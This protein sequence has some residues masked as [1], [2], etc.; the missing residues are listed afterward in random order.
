MEESFQSCF[1]REIRESVGYFQDF[2]FE[3]NDGTTFVLEINKK[4]ISFYGID[5]KRIFDC[6][7]L[8]KNELLRMFSVQ[9]IFYYGPNV[10]CTD[11]WNITKY[12]YI[13]G[14]IPEYVSQLK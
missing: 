5:D 10:E 8:Y 2:K 12:S 1:I 3:L 4:S 6:I 7:N 14:I 9:T 11:G 13:F